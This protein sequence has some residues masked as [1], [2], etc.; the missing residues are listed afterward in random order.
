MKF[1]EGALNGFGTPPCVEGR[2]VL[3]T[4]REDGRPEQRSRQG[5]PKEYVRVQVDEWLCLGAVGNDFAER[6][7]ARVA[8]AK[9]VEFGRDVGELETERAYEESLARCVSDEH[10]LRKMFARKAQ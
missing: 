1:S 7:P 8:V 6:P 5:L 9:V 2:M 10:G 4:L 3:W